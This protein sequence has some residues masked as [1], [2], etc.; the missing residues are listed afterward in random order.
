MTGALTLPR[1]SGGCTQVQCF[2]SCRMIPVQMMISRGTAMMALAK[3]GIAQLNAKQHEVLDP[4]LTR[5]NDKARER[6]NRKF[7]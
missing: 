4:L 3:G 1:C 5:V 6:L 7:R 2:F